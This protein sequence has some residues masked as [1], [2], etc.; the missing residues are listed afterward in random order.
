MKL[1]SKILIAAF[2]LSIAAA[3]VYDHL[4]AGAI[5]GAAIVAL[6]VGVGCRYGNIGRGFVYAIALFYFLLSTLLSLVFKEILSS[7]LQLLS[8]T[9]VFHSLIAGMLIVTGYLTIRRASCGIDISNKTFLAMAIPCPVCFGA[10]M[11]SC[12]FASLALEMDGLWLGA[13]LGA[14][15]AFGIVAIS[16]KGRTNPERLGT[17]MLLLGVYYVFSMLLIPAVIQGM[18]FEYR[19]SDSFDPYSLLL[20]LIMA[21]GA[22]RGAMRYD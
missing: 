10:L 19:I 5:A 15:I 18:S 8:Y 11:L 1:D 9:I 13:I 17:I 2:F 14:M 4:L 20:L 6:K 7:V 12:Y 3:M 16:S 21:L 22:I